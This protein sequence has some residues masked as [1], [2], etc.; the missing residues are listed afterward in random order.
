M[1]SRRVFLITAG[2]AGLLAADS[3]LTVGQA[4]E[5]IQKNLGVPW[6]TP[7]VDTLKAGTPDTPVQ[8]IATT[9]MA[10][11]DVLQRAAKAGRNFVIT[12]EP[13]FYNHE[14]TTT[15]FP[16]DPVYTAKRAFLESHGMAVLRFHDNW[17]ARRPDGI[18]T[19]MLQILGWERF[20]TDES[21]QLLVMPETSLEVLAG[22]AR[23]RLQ[24]R[25]VRVIGAP[26]MKVRRVAINPGYADL[27]GVMRTLSRPDVDVLLIGEAREWEGIP[28]VQ[29][30]IAAGRPK[31]LIVLG[32]VIS[33]E[34]GMNE[35]AR[36][37]K[38]FITEVPVEF[39]PAGEPF[40]SPQA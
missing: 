31:G 15:A 18:R 6:R 28:Y 8:G 16:A 30:S 10:T 36:W 23:K 13:T 24:A 14:D 33:E 17:H 4:I 32:H 5:R 2:A 11:F 19:G 26:Q 34:N 3:P 25:T 12:H 21:P 37:I 39:I 38:T 1:P 7:T 40:W 29:D 20:R 27:Q 35:C 22:D 9:M